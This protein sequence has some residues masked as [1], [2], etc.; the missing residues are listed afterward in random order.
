MGV[1]WKDFDLIVRF[2]NEGYVRSNV[3]VV[4]IGAQ[5]L[6]NDILRN[7]QKVRELGQAFGITNNID[8]PGPTASVLTQGKMEHLDSAAPFARLIWTW[9]GFEYASIDIDG[10]PESIPL[11]LN[12]DD[13]PRKLK[14]H[15]QLVTNLG[16]TEHV[17]N[18]LQAFKIIHDLTAPGGLMIHHLPTQGYMNHGL[19]NYN[20]KFFWMLARSNGYKWV[21]SDFTLSDQPYN[22]PENIADTVRT[23]EGSIDQRAKNYKAVDCGLVVALQKVVDIEFVPPIDVPTGAIVTDKK[24]RNRYWTVYNP[25]AFRM[26]KIPSRLLSNLRRRFRVS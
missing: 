13:V 23:H 4:E 17:A 9:L 5:Q 1:G 11:D 25:D 22:L 16:T 6:S 15:F 12:F 24:L 26:R 2:K 3:A 19:V 7:R 20:M 8:L 18:Q 10:S 21:Y 14:G